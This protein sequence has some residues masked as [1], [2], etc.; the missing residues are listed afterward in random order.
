MRSIF[1]RLRPE[2]MTAL[3]GRSRSIRSKKSAPAWTSISHAVG[4]SARLLYPATRFRCSTRS[5]P[6]GAY[7]CT[8]GSTPGYISF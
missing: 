8:R 3:P 7:T 5:Q 4:F 1:G 2:R 6:S